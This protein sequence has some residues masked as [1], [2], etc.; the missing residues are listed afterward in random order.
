MGLTSYTNNPK[1]DAIGSLLVGG[2]LGAVASF[3][4]YTNVAALVGQSIPQENLNKINDELE[5]DIMVIMFNIKND[6]I[7]KNYFIICLKHC[8]ILI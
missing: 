6:N 5:S 4:I 7:I 8:F 3:I 1:Y 2:L